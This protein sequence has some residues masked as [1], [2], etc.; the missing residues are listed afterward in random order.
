[1]TNEFSILIAGILGPILMVVISSELLNFNIWKNVDAK[2]ISVNGLVLLICGV[3]IIKLHNIWSL[4]WTLLIT[5]Y[6]WAIFLLGTYRLFFPNLK[7][8]PQNPITY[9]FLALIFASGCFLTYKGY[10]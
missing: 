9:L 1:M 7:Q 4:N 6:G 3:I 8:A 5:L 10:F 2:I